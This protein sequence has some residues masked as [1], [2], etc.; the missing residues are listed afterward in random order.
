M[1]DRENKIVPLRP[2]KPSPEG[3]AQREQEALLLAR[4]AAMPQLEYERARLAAAREL[5]CRVSWLDRKMKAI[6]YMIGECQGL[7]RAKDGSTV[8]EPINFWPANGLP[9]LGFVTATAHQHGKDWH[10]LVLSDGN[11]TCVR[12]TPISGEQLE[13]RRRLT[14]K[15]P[16]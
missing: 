16:T 9:V 8:G 7:P 1:Q 11:G 6:R 12:S 2:A 4:L 15:E 10:F 5:K 14:E 3:W 13:L